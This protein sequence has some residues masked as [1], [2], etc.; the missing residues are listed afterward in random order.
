[1]VSLVSRLVLKNY[2][3]EDSVWVSHGRTTLVK[4]SSKRLTPW[5]GIFDIF[6]MISIYTHVLSKDV[7][8][9][10]LRAVLHI[11][12][13]FFEFDLDNLLV[14]HVLLRIM[15]PKSPPGRRQRKG[16]Y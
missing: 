3:G 10:L 13:L 4:I 1:M 14:L 9:L 15:H 11:K 16:F 12:L 8:I 2:S 7:L 5:D 6:V